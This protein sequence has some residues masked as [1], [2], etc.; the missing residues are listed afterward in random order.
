MSKI[1]AFVDDEEQIL[2]ALKRL[3]RNTDHQCLFFSGQSGF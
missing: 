2:R 1:I 3:F